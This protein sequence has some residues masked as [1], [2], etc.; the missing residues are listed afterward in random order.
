MKA[1]I[2]GWITQGEGVGLFVE[3]QSQSI[4]ARDTRIV[5]ARMAFHASALMLYAGAGSKKQKEYAGAYQ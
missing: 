5:G 4:C 1:E 2:T 3:R